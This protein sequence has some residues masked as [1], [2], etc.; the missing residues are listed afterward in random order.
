MLS[1]NVAQMLIEG[2]GA[3]RTLEVSGELS[4]LDERNPGPVPVEGALSAVRTLEGVLVQGR[5]TMSLKQACRRC[6][7]FFESQ[8]EIEFEE[9]YL[10]LVDVITGVRINPGEDTEPEL[11]ISDR[12][13][14]D[15]R[16]VLRQYAVA[17]LQAPGLCREDCQGF[18]PDCGV[19]LNL[20]SCNCDQTHIDPRFAAL[21]DLLG[22][23]DE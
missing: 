14:L 21:A 1:F 9:E 19:N 18:C 7:E 11:L 15:T 13:I 16:E 3:T 8:C 6:L 23:G 5:V 22:S 20:E 2:V 10:S 12:H 17:F 4:D